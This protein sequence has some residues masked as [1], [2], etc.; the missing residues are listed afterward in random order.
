MFDAIYGENYH[1]SMKKLI[2]QK[3]LKDTIK[4]FIIITLSIGAIVWVVQAVGYLDFI[5]EDG[6]GLFVYFSYTFLNFPKIISRI[7]PFV[8]I[9]SLFYQILD[10]ERRNELLIFWVN[11]IT[12]L[13]FI[14]KIVIYSFLIALF[15]MFLSA[16][17]NPLT[18]AKARTF[19]LNSSTDFFPSLIK[20]G[21]F[22]D[23]VRGLTIFIESKNENGNFKNIF[24]SNNF[25]Y[26]KLNE[27]NSKKSEIIYAKEGVL[28][29]NDQER[30][31]QLLDG[32]IIKNDNKK[33]QEFT[34][35]KINYDLSQYVSNSTKYPKIREAPSTFLIKCVYYKYLNQL[36]NIENRKL[37]NTYYRCNDRSFKIVLEEFLQRIYKPVYLIILGLISSLLVLRSK[38]E[39]G[40]K[41]TKL[42]L[43]SFSFII[44]IISEISLRYSAYT[45]IGTLFFIFFPIIIFFLV[46]LTLFKRIKI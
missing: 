37:G 6:H 29:N 7:I 17:V 33:I 46:Y 1:I 36:E 31:F 13:E 21:K 45:L 15:Q 3:F 4:T 16:Y 35:E 14:N 18:Q 25:G 11:G 22:I 43:F 38:D 34:F 9:V 20:E 41:R 8:F 5:S 24:L 42:Y 2:F 32:R 23:V 19:V 28:I 26:E 30:Y 44:I 40:Y 39:I 10:Y 27:I 12:K